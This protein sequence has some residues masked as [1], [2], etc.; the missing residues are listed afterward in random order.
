VNY[1][2]YERSIIIVLYEL[3]RQRVTLDELCT[4]RSNS[5]L[6]SCWNARKMAVLYST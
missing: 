5:V 2:K 4:K 6:L 1:L 3:R